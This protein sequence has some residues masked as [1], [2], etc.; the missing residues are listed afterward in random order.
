MG[1]IKDKERA[2]EK[3]KK[4]SEAYFNK[5][6]KLDTGQ[7][8]LDFEKEV[9]DYIKKRPGKQTSNNIIGWIGGKAKVADALISMMPQHQEYCEVFF[10]G[11]SIFFKKHKSEHNFINDLNSNLVNM[12]TVIR[13]QSEE[14]WK[15]AAFFLYSKDI[16]DYVA[17]KYNGHDWNEFTPV[18]KAV[19]FYFLCKISFNDGMT[20]FSRDQEF[21]IWDQFQNIIKA[22]EKLQNVCIDN[23]DFR[24]FIEKRI[25]DCSKRKVMFYMDPPYL[26]A[27]PKEYYEYLFTDFEHSDLARAC[28]SIDRAGGYFMLSYEDTQIIRDLYRNYEQKYIELTYSLASG[29]LKKGVKGKEIIITNFKMPSEQLRMEL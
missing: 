17:E 13:D 26:I 15:Y 1:E 23:S 4:S 27:Q 3:L 22:A 19:I 21:S 25:P 9:L 20:S 7:I 12:Y 28:D 11:G 18:Q 6:K 8:R 16:F 24:V 29:M 10:G 14:F 5:Q 2:L